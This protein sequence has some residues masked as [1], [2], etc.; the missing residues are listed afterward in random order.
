MEGLAS[1][2]SCTREPVAHDEKWDL[3]VKLKG[4][5]AARG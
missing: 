2:Y 3:L 4:N 1:G 5:S